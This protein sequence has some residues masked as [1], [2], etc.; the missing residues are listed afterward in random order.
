[1]DPFLA[2]KPPVEPLSLSVLEKK[3]VRASVLRLDL[4][5]PLVSGNK[6]FKLR[7]YLTDALAQHKKRVITFGGAWSNHLLAT[8]AACQ[9]LGLL[10]AACIRGERPAKLS[11]TLTQA[12]SL[13]MELFFLTREQYRLKMIPDS[14]TT[15]DDY[16]IQEGGTGALG[17]KGAAT[18]LDTVDREQYSHI[19]CAAGTGTTLAGLINA[20]PPTCQVIG[21]PVLSD[22]SDI[23]ATLREQLQDRSARWQLQTGYEW[24]GYAKH[25]AAL[26]HFMNEL[27]A[28]S[29]IPTDIVYTGKL[30]YACL[31]LVEKD[32]FKE[33]SRLLLV[34]SGGLQGNRSLSPDV[35]CF[36]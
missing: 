10:S 33:G 18:I 7:Y 29:N 24:G 25:P 17:V 36:T 20:A 21:I 14:L 11:A 34:H 6:W 5:H 3:N 4:L 2:I 23:D 12:Q 30:F 19:L 35:L 8:A 16:L 26:L 9:E 27:F 15:Q 22:T 1:M 31:A 28:Q 13:G 32:H